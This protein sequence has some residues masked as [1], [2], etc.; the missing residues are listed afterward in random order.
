MCRESKRLTPFEPKPLTP[1]EKAD[2]QSGMLVTH[3]IDVRNANMLGLSRYESMKHNG[4]WE[5]QNYIENFGDTKK[6]GH[7]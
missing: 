1:A 4:A 3:R 2:L 5:Y 6:C 7:M